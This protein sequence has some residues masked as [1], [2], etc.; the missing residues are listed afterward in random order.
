LQLLGRIR[1][2]GKAAVREGLIKPRWEC[3]RS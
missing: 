2:G 1:H 3:L